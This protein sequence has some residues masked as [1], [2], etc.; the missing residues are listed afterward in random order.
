MRR[1]RAID[2]F[3]VGTPSIIAL[4]ALEVRYRHRAQR[5]HRRAA[6]EVGR[7]VGTVHRARR[8]TCAGSRARARLATRCGTTRLAGE[9]CACE[10]WPVVQALI[11]RGVIGDCRRGGGAR[12]P[13]SCASASRPCTTATS[14][15]GTRSRHCA[16][17][18]SAVPG[19]E[20]E[21]R[22]DKAVY[23]SDE[24]S[25]SS[26]IG[27]ARQA[28]CGCGSC[29]GRSTLG[30]GSP[31]MLERAAPPQNWLRALRGAALRHL[32]RYGLN[33]AA[34]PRAARP[35]LLGAPEIASSAC[36]PPRSKA[37]PRMEALRRRARW[38]AKACSGSLEGE[39][40]V[41]RSAGAGARA[42][43]APRAIQLAALV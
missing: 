13:T 33:V 6:R 37:M 14:T 26:T 24:E 11:A 18:S 10:C 7:A 34:A 19:I 1:R 40:E 39:S 8:R 30:V 17:S 15:S 16:T 41:P 28:A 3:T 20:P 5:R 32:R 36:H 23:V 22:A 29:R 43:S 25:P 31:A 38:C 42:R 9:L 2:R 27:A 4:A 21:F 35:P 12:R